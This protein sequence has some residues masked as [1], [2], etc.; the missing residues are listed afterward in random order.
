MAATCRPGNWES[1]MSFRYAMYGML[2]G[3]IIVSLTGC[4]VQGETDT[5]ALYCAGFC[6]M[7]DK[8]VEVEAT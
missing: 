5:G 4:A 2:V 1:G 6:I 7:K 3:L 8:K